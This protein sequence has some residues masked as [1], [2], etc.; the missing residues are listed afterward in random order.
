[1][2]TL[3]STPAKLSVSYTTIAKLIGTESNSNKLFETLITDPPTTLTT[4]W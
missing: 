3:I 4:R 2:K 1:M